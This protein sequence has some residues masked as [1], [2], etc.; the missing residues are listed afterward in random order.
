MAAEIGRQPWVVYNL[1]RTK[2][3]VSASVPAGQILASIILFTLIYA[4]LFGVWLYLLGRQFNQ[5]PQP[6]EEEAR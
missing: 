2:D 6:L 5:G 3:A 1:M 4:L